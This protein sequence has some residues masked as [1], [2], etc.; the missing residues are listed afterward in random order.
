MSRIQEPV[1]IGRL[2]FSIN[3]AVFIFNRVEVLFSVRS[4]WYVVLNGLPSNYLQIHL[5]RELSG[6]QPFKLKAQFTVE[7]WI[8]LSTFQ[9]HIAPNVNLNLE[10]HIYE[11]EKKGNATEI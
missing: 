1:I 2:I 9:I 6:F 5:T 3:F 11:H 4:S 10:E 8:K 7:S